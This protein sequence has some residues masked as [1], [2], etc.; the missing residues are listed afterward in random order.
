LQIAKEWFDF[1][2]EHFEK[3]FLSQE[4]I[5]ESRTYY[6]IDIK[7]VVKMTILLKFK[8]KDLPLLVFCLRIYMTVKMKSDAPL[9]L[10]VLFMYE[11][12]YLFPS[13]TK[14]YGGRGMEQ[15]SPCSYVL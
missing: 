5:N 1:I 7:F 6:E 12:G 15:S 3:E 8:K 10:N 14:F 2:L 13:Q 9:F 11:E 4:L